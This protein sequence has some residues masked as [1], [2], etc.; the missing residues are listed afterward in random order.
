MARPKR[1]YRMAMPPPVRGLTRLTG[2]LLLAAMMAA[3]AGKAGVSSP[4]TEAPTPR[5]SVSVP[6]DGVTLAAFGF[7][8]GPVGEFSLPRSTVLAA[9]V[10]QANNVAVVLSSPAPSEVADYLRRSLPVAGF[11]LRYD[12]SGTMTFD[13]YGWAGSFTSTDKPAGTGASSAVLLRPQ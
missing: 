10:D 12:Q 2:I 4:T 6:A 5:R 11:D 3:C 13:G 8:N 1:Y 7:A 9:K